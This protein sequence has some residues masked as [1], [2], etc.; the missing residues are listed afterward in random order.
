MLFSRFWKNGCISEV[1]PGLSIHM[2]Y[3]T[4][5]KNRLWS[6]YLDWLDCPPEKQGGPVTI[7]RHLLRLLL[8]SSRQ[9]KRNDLSLRSSALTYAILLSMVPMLAMSTAVVKG[10]GGGNQLR[11][12]AYTYIE[13]LERLDKTTPPQESSLV[14]SDEDSATNL[15]GHLR[16]AVDQLF[17][18]VDR[19]NF[20]T[21]GSFGVVG[22]LL[23]VLM[24]LG[25]IETAMNSIWR[26]SAGRPILRKIA[27]YITM[28]ILLPLSI[29]LAFA[30]SAFLNN[31]RLAL[32]FDSYIPLVWI[33]ALLLQAVPVFF[34]TVSFYAMYIFFPN[35]KVKTLPA[36]I[37]ATIAACCWV[38]IQN[39]FISMQIGVANYNAI[40]GS[41]ATF[42]L[43][44]VWIYLSWIFI[45]AGAQI[46][47]AIQNEKHFNI[48]QLK[49]SPSI[50][51]S[52]AF[53]IMDEVFQAFSKGEQLR[54]KH[55]FSTLS[56]YPQQLIC[57]ISET[58]TAHGYISCPGEEGQILPLYPIDQYDKATIVKVILGSEAPE[59]NGGKLSL[60]AIQAA[61]HSHSI[62]TKDQLNTS[63]IDH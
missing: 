56:T 38:I 22:I 46:A 43:F 60:S 57:T 26:V 8:I 15:T 4:H 1:K 12:A 47:Y 40:Y 2:Q 32:K 5:S 49:I 59:T 61:M 52:C 31:P 28:L 62:E 27:D 24:V 42:P 6:T 48:V 44:L 19:T 16:S 30:A 3:I 58:L 25:N 29:N 35:T 39:I 34:I 54:R 23:S 45:L 17:D 14:A 41:F 36:V 18:Y 51:L 55:L 10:L 53:D 11:D 9:F 21:L 20:A 37:G 7:L 63:Q 13:T 33:Q 50:Q